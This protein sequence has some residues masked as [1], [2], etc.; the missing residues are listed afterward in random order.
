MT[1]RA[2]GNNNVPP[3]IVA[4][5]GLEFQITKTKLYVPVVTLPKKKNGKKKFATTK[6]RI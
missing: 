1:V 4:A 6:I 2:V 3:A 5:T